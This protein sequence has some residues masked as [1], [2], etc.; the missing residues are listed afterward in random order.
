MDVGADASTLGPVLP[1]WAD[2]GVAE[3]NIHRFS[4]GVLHIALPLGD[5]SNTAVIVILST[6]S[7]DTSTTPRTAAGIGLGSSTSEVAAAYPDIAVTDDG[8]R[9][10]HFVVP[11]GPRYVIVLLGGDGGTVNSIW[12]SDHPTLP[13]DLC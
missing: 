10:A 8:N 4:D 13:M 12:V 6:E 2:Q 7:G 5:G 11:D 9:T 3:C 1:G